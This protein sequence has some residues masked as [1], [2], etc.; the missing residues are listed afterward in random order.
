MWAGKKL[1]IIFAFDSDFF[2]PLVRMP[3]RCRFAGISA[4]PLRKNILHENE[5]SYH[6][7]TKD[8]RRDLKFFVCPEKNKK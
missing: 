3:E 7:V 4:G 8:G 1:K 5:R 6:G 2:T